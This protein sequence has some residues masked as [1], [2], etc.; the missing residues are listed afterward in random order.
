MPI[1]KIEFD[2]VSLIICCIA[3]IVFHKQKQMNTNRNTLFYVIIICIS[4]SAVFSL[5]NS[6]ALNHLATSSIYFAYITNTL[7]LVFHTHVPF[8]FCI[9]IFILTEY[10]LPN[11]TVRILFALPWIAFLL[12]IFGN[13]FHH[14]LFYFTKNQYHRGPLHLVLYY[15]TAIYIGIAL[16][17]LFLRKRKLNAIE[18]SSFLVALIFP[19]IAIFLQIFLQGM[20]LENFSLS[21]SVLF[22]LLIVQNDKN[23]I[24]VITGLQ[25]NLA[26]NIVLRDNLLQKNPFTITFVHSRELKTIQTYLDNDTY[27][28][29]LQKISAWFINLAKKRFHLFSL[30]DT[31]FALVSTRHVKDETIGELSL[32]IIRRSQEAW[33]LGEIEIQLTFQTSIIRVPDDCKTTNQ[34]RDYIEQFIDLT[35]IYS[36]R[37]IIFAKDFV[38]ENHLRQARIAYALQEKIE[39]NTLDLVYQPI[40]ATKTKGIFAIEAL[41]SLPLNDGDTIQ[42]SEILKVA[43]RIGLGKRLGECI[44]KNVFSWYVSERLEQHNLFVQIRLLESFCFEINWAQNI[45]EI[46]KKTGMSLSF[47]CLQLTETAIANTLDNLK[48]NMDFLKSKNVSFALDDYGSGYTDF[49]EILEIPFTTVKLDK[50]IVHAAFVDTL[51]QRLLEGTVSLFKKLNWPIVAEGVETDEHMTYLQELGLEYFQGYKIGYP[52][53]GDKLLE[54]LKKQF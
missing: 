4:L 7:Y 28:S 11:R 48:H 8:L 1:Y 3:F 36:D 10:R 45:L 9:Y 6:L 18:I 49:G 2:I 43:E 41:I 17:V 24:D 33:E 35:E 20:I 46:A 53:K 22:L 16:L 31:L 14:A 12:L 47:L 39:K 29:L 19:L 15:L 51:G 5:L 21:I 54:R 26:F 34:I 42:Q 13:P 52:E 23:L 25:N 38:P 37:H 30:N 32:D 27:N 50:K 44:I 40:Y